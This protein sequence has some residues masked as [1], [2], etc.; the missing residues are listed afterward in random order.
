MCVKVGRFLNDF[1]F[2]SELVDERG[3]VGHLDAGAALGWLADFE[4]L[5]ARLDIDA[6]RF[7]LVV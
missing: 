7:G 2:V 3:D 4:R 6:E 1:G 5:D